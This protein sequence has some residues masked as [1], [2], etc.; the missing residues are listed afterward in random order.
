MELHLNCPSELTIWSQNWWVISTSMGRSKGTVKLELERYVTWTLGIYTWVPVL[1]GGVPRG[2]GIFLSC[3]ARALGSPRVLGCQGLS[4]WGFQDHPGLPRT[5][6]ADCVHRAGGGSCIFLHCAVAPS[7]SAILN[8]PTPPL[9][10]R[11]STHV[12][13]FFFFLKMGSH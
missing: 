5:A 3:D 8:P 4:C 12:L 6:T 11:R 9:A 1:S 13:F 2:C 7:P 10:T